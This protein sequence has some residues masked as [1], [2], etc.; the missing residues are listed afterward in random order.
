MR[1]IE[2]VEKTAMVFVRPRRKVARFILSVLDIGAGFDSHDEK[3]S[4]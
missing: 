3:S 1:E 2:I 4:S